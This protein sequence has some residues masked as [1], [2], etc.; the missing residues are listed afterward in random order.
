MKKYSLMCCVFVLL[1]APLTSW[2]QMVPTSARIMVDTVECVPGEMFA[3]TIRLES[4]VV[5]F[6]GLQLPLKFASDFVTIDSVSFGGSLKPAGTT[7]RAEIDVATDTMAITYYPAFGPTPFAVVSEA[8][9]TLATIHGRL[10]SG[11]APGYISVDSIY[12]PVPTTNWTG[13]GFSDA[14]GSGLYVPAGFVSGAI[15][16]LSPTDVGDS[17]GL[18]PTEFGLAQNYPNPF[19]PVTTIEFALPAAG[20]TRIDIFNIL[21]QTVVTPVNESLSAGLHTLS[22]DASNQP[23]G[24]YFYKLSHAGG[25]ETR[26]MVLLK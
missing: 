16:V 22:F 25:T 23:S 8:A 21:G 7:G 24:I 1:L 9:G 19:N 2:S 12:H 26:K 17:P 4:S 13:I 3:L 14:L 5:P 6:A 18:L 11:A 15:K 20:P 10:E